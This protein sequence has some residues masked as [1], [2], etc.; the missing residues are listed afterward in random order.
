ME[1]DNVAFDETTIN[2]NLVVYSLGEQNIEEH[3]KLITNNLEASLDFVKV[4]FRKVKK[5]QILT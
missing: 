3:D 5:K 1:V 4:Y 2:F